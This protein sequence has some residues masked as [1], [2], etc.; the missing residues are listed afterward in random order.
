MADRD[1]PRCPEPARYSISMMSRRTAGRFP[2]G[3]WGPE[4]L[5]AWRFLLFSLPLA[6]ERHENH[7]LASVIF[8]R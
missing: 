2:V 8:Y 4:R 6:Y 1:P 7:K 3:G 5:G